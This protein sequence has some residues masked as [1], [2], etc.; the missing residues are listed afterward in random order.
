MIKFRNSI[1]YKLFV[2]ACSVTFLGL[3]VLLYVSAYIIEPAFANLE[4]EKA[5]NEL[6]LIQK[7]IENELM[8]LNLACKDWG[9]WDDLYT[10]VNERNE[11]FVESN[12]VEDSFYSTNINLIYI[13]NKTGEPVFGKCYNLEGK[14]ELNLPEITGKKDF[15]P[16]VL[17][18][19]S[20][21]D[22]KVYINF[23]LIGDRYMAVLSRPI[24]PSDGKEPYRGT[25]MMGKFIDE[26][27]FDKIRNNVGM[28]FEESQVIGDE[29]LTGVTDIVEKRSEIFKSYNYRYLQ[30]DNKEQISSIYITQ[31]GK[32]LFIISKEVEG[33]ITAL[34]IVTIE[35]LLI[36]I[37]VIFLGL[38]LIMGI[39]TQRI[40]LKPLYK[41]VR[42]I[43]KIQKTQK[44]KIEHSIQRK[45]E[46]GY[47]AIQFNDLLNSIRAKSKQLEI[48]ATTDSMTGILNHKSIIDRLTSEISRAKRYGN[49][50]SASVIDIDYFKQINDK[51]GHQTGDE[52]IKT[53]V[54]TIQ[55]EIRDSDILGRYGGDEFLLVFIDQNIEHSKP[56]LERIYHSIGNINWPYPGMNV[57]ISCGLVELTD[58]IETTRELIEKADSNLYCAKENGRNNFVSN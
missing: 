49:K 54:A 22:R 26:K 2:T 24:L 13:Y 46:I 45:D 58:D 28:T 33:K 39:L 25:L 12:L 17:I 41:M 44:L 57:S 5:Q 11:N 27:F 56:A 21:D 40:V 4:H 8:H 10:F 42:E 32:P 14:K 30:K 16:G 36:M 47:L 20:Y 53:I 52:V 55:E 9:N 3:F 34:G 48:M 19:E 15:N 1:K 38:F 51:F 29:A 37:S 31:T 50:L 43:A 7:S 6:C 35:S 23:P 18:P